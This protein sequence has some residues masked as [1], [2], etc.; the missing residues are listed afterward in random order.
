MKNNYDFFCSLS[1]FTASSFSSPPV[2]SLRKREKD[3]ERGKEA[4]EEEQ[5]IISEQKRLLSLTAKQYQ[6][7]RS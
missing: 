4:E 7:Y 1:S 6:T 3:L 5:S 2:S